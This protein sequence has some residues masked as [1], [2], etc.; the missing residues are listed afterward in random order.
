MD[1]DIDTDT[2]T[3]TDTDLFP[4]VDKLD[5]H[6]SAGHNLLAAPHHRKPTPAHLE[7]GTALHCTELPQTAITA[8]HVHSSPHLLQLYV[9]QLEV[10]LPCGVV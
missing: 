9:L 2:D 5:R 8:L 3:D 10:Q 7:M 1:T 6:F 4:P